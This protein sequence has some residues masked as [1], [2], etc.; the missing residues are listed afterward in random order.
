MLFV[1]VCFGFILFFSRDKWLCSVRKP[2]ERGSLVLSLYEV[3]AFWILFLSL[4]LCFVIL[5]LEFILFE[6]IVN[7][8]LLDCLRV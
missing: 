5:G 2:L 6:I 4:F 7:F 1:V 8:Y 3:G